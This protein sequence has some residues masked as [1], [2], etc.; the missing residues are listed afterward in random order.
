MI[1]SK[2]IVIIPNF[3]GGSFL[4]DCLKS[5]S[6]QTISHD[7]LI[8]DNASIDGSIDNALKEFPATI[9]LKQSKN[10]G[11]AG[12]VNRGIKYAQINQYQYLA[13]LNNDALVRP[14]WLENLLELINQ[15]DKI[16]IVAPKVLRQD[17][18]DGHYLI[19]S[20]GE[21]YALAG[22][23]YPKARNEQDRGQY[24]VAREIPMASG[25]ASIYRTDIFNEIGLFDEKFFIYYEDC[26]ISLRARR[27]GYSIWYQPKSVVYHGVGKTSGGSNTALV[28][29][30][31]FK[32]LWMIFLKNLPL[33]YLIMYLP[34]MWL[35]SF[36][37]LLSSIKQG[38][39]LSIIKAKFFLLIHINT[40]LK[41][42]FDIQRNSIVEVRDFMSWFD[43]GFTPNQRASLTKIKRK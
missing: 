15:D 28:R 7:V 37:L 19:D 1:P 42:R 6:K 12:G 25:A 16:A 8:I 27:K 22:G 32:N 31:M 36:M 3:N 34:A 20:I 40:I 11:F 23:P 38:N 39:I 29:Y 9:V 18:K 26:D 24:N 5:L 4:L 33:T 35:T 21:Y 13:I 41:D 17:K 30:H 2:P 10:H 14:N 43:P